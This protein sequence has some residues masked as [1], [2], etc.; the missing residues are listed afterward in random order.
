MIQVVLVVQLSSFNTFLRCCEVKVP[1]Q[2]H[3]VGEEDSVLDWHKVNVDN[4]R[5]CPDLPI[6][7]QRAHEL[8]AVIKM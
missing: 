7:K 2:S 8:L 5:D 1:D 3:K 6:G 4:L